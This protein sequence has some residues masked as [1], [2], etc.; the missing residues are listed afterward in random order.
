M[1][2][3]VRGRMLPETEGTGPA[4]RRLDVLLWIGQLTDHDL[5]TLD[6]VENPPR[7]LVGAET[8][9]LLYTIAR[10]RLSRRD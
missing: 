7:I 1:S 10:P 3:L 2:R 5:T 9:S 8:P 4:K 6:R